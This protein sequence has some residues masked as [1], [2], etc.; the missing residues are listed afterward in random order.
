M[1]P[2]VTRIQVITVPA[3]P[4]QTGQRAKVTPFQQN[5]LL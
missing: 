3:L 1:Q 4:K 2:N 5:P